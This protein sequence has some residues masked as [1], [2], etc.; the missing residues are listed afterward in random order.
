MV[1]SRVV[2]L[3]DWSRLVRDPLDL[4]RIGFA[5]AAVVYGVF[6]FG[7]AVNLGVAAV[8]V[9]AVRF[10]NL[11]QP[12]DLAFIACMWLTGWGEALRLYDKFVHYDV[13]VHFLVPLLGAPIVY[14]ALSRL[15][16][17]SEPREHEERHHYVGLFLVTLAFGLAL[18]AA[19]EIAEWSSDHLFGSKLQTGESDTIGDL[20]ADACGAAFGGALLVT[21]A[22]FG[23]GT[24]R[25]I[26]AGA[27]S[28]R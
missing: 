7:G 14:I 9:I 20:V 15:D 24:V 4:L 13:V 16:V 27:V 3:G 18:G 6:G 12:Y 22:A 28:G 10:L 1:D 11:P 5:V 25:R 17:L 26:P 19:W 2:L 21:W 8:A 23:W